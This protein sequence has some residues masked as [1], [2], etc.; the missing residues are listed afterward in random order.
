MNTIET[1]AAAYDSFAADYDEWVG[2]HPS[3]RRAK[4]A[5]LRRARA[6]T[7]EGDEILDAGCGTGSEAIMLARL[8]RRVVGC[9]VAPRMLQIADS[10]AAKAGPDIQ[11]RT[12][13][14]LGSAGDVCAEW[15]S[16]G[17][18]DLAYSAYGVLNLEPDPPTALGALAASVRPGGHVL[19]GTLNPTF[20]LEL[21]LWPLAGR[22]KGFRKAAQPLVELK[23][24]HGRDESVLCRLPSNRALR[25]AGRRCGLDLI[26]EVGLHVL[27][28]PPSEAILRR[29]PALVAAVNRME[30]R[31]ESRFPANRLGYFS[32][33][34]FRRAP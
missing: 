4:A 16:K 11:E 20:F 30:S 23:I 31:I 7:Q 33:L 29:A 12:R 8:K 9:D 32:L 2:E 14:L 24:G 17:A 21:V 28:P 15:A 10:K 13:F 27:L 26:E 19:V 6:L 34:V 18:F 3:A 22:L 25:D 1:A 5:V